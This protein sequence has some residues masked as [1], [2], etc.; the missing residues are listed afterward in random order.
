[1]AILTHN[2]DVR[3]DGALFAAPQPYRLGWVISDYER[4]GKSGIEHHEDELGIKLYSDDG[5]GGRVPTPG[6]PLPVSYFDQSA[7]DTRAGTLTRRLHIEVLRRYAPT[8]FTDADV[9]RAG[10][11]IMSD[12]R[13]FS[14]HSGGDWFRYNPRISRMN[15][16][17]L[18]D[19]HPVDKGGRLVWPVRMLKVGSLEGMRQQLIDYPLLP[20]NAST[21]LRWLGGRQNDPFWFLGGNH[22]KVLP[23]FKSDTNWIDAVDIRV[24]E[25]GEIPPNSYF[26]AR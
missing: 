4:W 9:V 11:G 20:F 23:F 26:P 24:L 14:D 13:A 3:S 25:P 10:L 8:G 1:M 18:M 21:S 15:V 19:D 16:V 12:D 7:T 2:F 6:I 17:Y 5:A 22:C